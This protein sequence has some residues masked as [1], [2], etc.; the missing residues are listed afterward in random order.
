MLQAITRKLRGSQRALVM[1]LSIAALGLSACVA[2][3]IPEGEE[4]LAELGNSEQ[5]LVPSTPH[6][7]RMCRNTTSGQACDA[8]Q[9]GGGQVAYCPG[10]SC[11][12]QPWAPNPDHDGTRYCAADEHIECAERGAGMS[13]F[14]A[15]GLPPLLPQK[16]LPAY[17]LELAITEADDVATTFAR[18]DDGSVWG[19]GAGSLLARSSEV[20]T[21]VRLDLEGKVTRVTAGSRSAC[22]L[23]QSGTVQCWGDMGLVQW[24]EPHTVEIA[25]GE[26]LTSLIGLTQAENHACA[27]RADG[28]VF[29]WG[30]GSYRRFGD[31]DCGVWEEAFEV[32]GVSDA[33]QV[34]AS[35]FSTCFLRSAGTVA[36]L[37]L[38]H[39]GQLGTGDV[40]E[41]D[42]APPPSTCVKSLPRDAC[43][44]TAVA[45]DVPGL[46][47]VLLLSGGGVGH[48]C[49]ETKGGTKCWGS[50]EYGRLALPVAPGVTQCFAA[51]ATPISRSEGPYHVFGPGNTCT[52]SPRGRAACWGARASGLLLDGA[53]THLATPQ[54]LPF[55]QNITSLAL[56][57]RHACYAG[58]G[59]I[60][61]WGSRDNGRLG[62]GG[63]APATTVMMPVASFTVP[64]GSAGDRVSSF[65]IA[66]TNTPGA[67]CSLFDTGIDVVG[68]KTFR[69][70]A[71]GTWSLGPS[72]A[73]VCGANGT[74]TFGKT[75]EGF[76]YGGLAGRI[77][78]GPLFWL[79]ASSTQTPVFGGRLRLGMLDTD[80]GN[81]SGALSVTVTR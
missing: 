20:T 29:C 23:M 79:G 14:C 71:T 41:P 70:S 74:S 59:V 72:A 55:A 12:C 9:C 43:A 8:V 5:A 65:T 19:W 47:N 13:C 58:E 78:T 37:G 27:W 32:P 49:A 48:F 10:G 36:C 21:P 53:T 56:G 6:W 61:C 38:S 11:S 34:V 69:V 7:Y 33:V 50:N 60:R 52:W 77:G 4:E 57:A 42:R 26:P 73:Y 15:R 66:G 81:N 46:K 2:E 28:R 1:V 18:F 75:P 16:A 25:F 63:S 67:G 76:D 54:A 22:A 68:G 35:A 3:V 80:C 40:D 64:G 17:P 24:P 51:T 62:D 31:A 45:Q 39:V 30:D 44:G